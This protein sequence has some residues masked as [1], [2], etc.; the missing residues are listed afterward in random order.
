MR[1][2]ASLNCML[3]IL[4]CRM[5]LAGAHDKKSKDKDDDNDQR[6]AV[7]IRDGMHAGQQHFMLHLQVMVQT[8]GILRKSVHH[9]RPRI[10]TR[11]CSRVVL[12]D[13]RPQIIVGSPIIAYSLIILVLQIYIFLG[14]YILKVRLFRKF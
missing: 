2:Q 4:S 5:S 7:L 8:N 3:R 9:F 14:I 1:T 12:L 10:G 11:L 6:S 13:I